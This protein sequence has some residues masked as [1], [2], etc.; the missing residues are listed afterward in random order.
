MCMV[1]WGGESG[2]LHAG[3]GEGEGLVE[4]NVSERGGSRPF[5]YMNWLIGTFDYYIW[6]Q[7]SWSNGSKHSFGSYSHSRILGFYSS[8]FALESR[9]AGIYFLRIYSY[10]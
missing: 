10:S 5:I 2:E 8:Y 6:L 1:F 7:N 4:Q 9:I 3:S